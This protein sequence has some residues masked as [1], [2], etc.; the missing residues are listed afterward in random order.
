MSSTPL[1]SS[2]GLPGAIQDHARR[3]SHVSVLEPSLICLQPVF[4]RACHS[5][6]K[7]IAQNHLVILRALTLAYLVATSAMIGHYKINVEVSETTKFKHLFSFTMVCHALVFV[8]HLITWAWTF[9]HLYHPDRHAVRGGVESVIIKVMSLPHNMGSLRKQF[10]FTLFYS[11]ATVFSFMNSVIYWFITRAHEAGGEDAMVAAAVSGLDVLAAPGKDVSA[12]VTAQMP[13]QP[14]SD[15]F[16]EG[17]FK[18]FVLITLHAINPCIMAIEI[19]FFNS[20]KRPFALGSHF[21]GLMAM[22]GLYLG[23]A[24]IGKALTGEFPFFWLD[25]E[26][27]GSK[28]A[29]TTYCVGFVFLSQILYILMQGFIYIREGLTKSIQGAEGS[30][31]ALHS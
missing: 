19:L 27:V 24:A 6:W 16:G 30:N 12:L 7:F 11:T 28:E 10:Y 9:T 3:P 8:Y 5:P 31:G 2:G 1:L 29:V 21:V 25:E 23:W 15:L 18:A 17:W 4:L 20:I 13:E 22:C 14:F 26:E